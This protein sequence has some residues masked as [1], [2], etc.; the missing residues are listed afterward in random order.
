MK[1]GVPL[2]L[3]H[4]GNFNRVLH[5]RVLLVAIE[6]TET[7]RVDDAERVTVTALSDRI[8]RIELKFGF[9][10][11][12]DVPQGLQVAVARGQIASCNLAQV[13]YFTGHETII[14]TRRQ[15]AMAQWRSGAVAQ[16]RSGAVAQWRSGAKQFSR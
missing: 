7:P 8:A 13:T 11:K 1:P 5:E 15:S 9:M 16:W 2:P 6:M 12:A 3:T 10:E 4:N 14:P